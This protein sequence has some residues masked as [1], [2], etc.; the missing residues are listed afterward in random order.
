MRENRVRPAHFVFPA[1]VLLI[2]LLTATGV[3][4]QTLLWTYRS[5]A[6][7]LFTP[8]VGT[9]G[10]AYFA[11]SGSKIEAV[12]A[13]GDVLWNVDPGGLPSAGMALY[14]GFLYFP[15]SQ[16]E[17][18]AYGTN[19]QLAWRRDLGSDIRTI[20]AVAGDGTIYVGTVDGRLVAINAAG[21]V[22]WQVGLGSP[23]LA[24]PVVT[25][26]GDI[27][28]AS[29][30]DLFEFDSSGTQVWQLHAS[31]HITGRLAVD[32]SDS[33]YFTDDA[34]TVWSV[35]SAGAEIWT[36][37]VT[38]S[39]ASPVISGDHV[40][41]VTSDQNLYGLTL[42]GGSQDWTLAKGSGG[43]PALSQGNIL[44]LG[45]TDDKVVYELDTSTK[46]DAGKISSLPGAPGD[47]VLVQT[48]RGP[49]LYFT[50]DGGYLLCFSAPYGPDLSVPWNQLGAG[51]R[52]LFRR[53]TPP[54]VSFTAPDDKATVSG[55][56]TLTADA[57]DD[58][59]DGLQVRFY[60]GDQLIDA[61]KRPPFETTW[62]TSTVA[63]GTYTLTV[64]ARDSAGQITESRITVTVDNGGR[65]T[66]IYA[67]TP[68]PQFSWVPGSE[69]RFRVE[70]SSDQ[71]FGLLLTSSNSREHH[72]IKSDSWRPSERKWKK[73]L[74]AAAGVMEADTPVYWRVLGKGGTVAS[75][76]AFHIARPEAAALSSPAEGS[77]THIAPP[78]EFQW[79]SSHNKRF[80]VEFSA[81][82][83]FAGGPSVTS[84]KQGRK[85]TKRVSWTPGSKR[86]KKIR[87]IGTTIYWRVR[88][89]DAIGRE[90]TALARSFS[91]TP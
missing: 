45:S 59:P 44:Y 47:M 9:D 34:G 60:A 62:V 82:A 13:S 15:T 1:F 87:A 69:S 75:S 29:Y 27:V 78:P 3:P 42:D 20:P 67:D 2:S 17:L 74:A 65:P 11:L 38:S 32:D 71:D 55:T 83:D 77:E 5:E 35:S 48:T 54:A 89:R 63:D 25:H 79:T 21:Q 84:S 10:T 52:H 68:P 80:I 66:V 91:I 23:V 4:A 39:G 86:W 22:K 6:P 33:V 50:C 14:N 70:F 41:I 73:V 30:D 43:T 18:V 16:E 90:T 8:T 12:S 7:I 58:F 37:T 24:S 51:P 72:W 49:R 36:T 85:W 64:Q 19:G 26:A 57:N 76:G 31:S 88:A 56:V 46:A 40:Y 61:V 28:I 53:D 81:T